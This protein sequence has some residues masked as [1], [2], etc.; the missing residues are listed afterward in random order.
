MKNKA[1]ATIE[2]T[3][4]VILVLLLLYGFIMVFRWVGLSYVERRQAQEGSLI[5]STKEEEQVMD[6]LDSYR[7]RHLQAVY[8]GNIYGM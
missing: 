2:F 7:P 3:F 6:R 4:A 1:Q 5:S 8:K